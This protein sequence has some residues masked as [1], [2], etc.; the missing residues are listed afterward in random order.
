[1]ACANGLREDPAAELFEDLR[2]DELA[3]NA[4]EAMRRQNGGAG[5][6]D[7]DVEAARARAREIIDETR[8]AESKKAPGGGAAGPLAGMHEMHALSLSIGLPVPRILFGQMVEASTATAAQK[9]AWHRQLK[10]MSKVKETGC[11]QADFFDTGTQEKNTAYLVLEECGEDHDLG[12]QLGKIYSRI[13]P[14][15]QGEIRRHLSVLIHLGRSAYGQMLKKM[16]PVLHKVGKKIPAQGGDKPFDP[17]V[18][19]VD[20]ANTTLFIMPPGT[21]RVGIFVRLADEIAAA[22]ATP[23][24]ET[25]ANTPS[26]PSSASEI[27]GEDGGGDE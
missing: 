8:A 23:P 18:L 4:A 11:I 20:P 14:E 26:G 12:A 27:G 21:R 9:K 2:I 7:A 3:E 22:A 17:C 1:M 25:P 19:G 15:K 6:T 24:A 5:L 10:G 13:P 16:M